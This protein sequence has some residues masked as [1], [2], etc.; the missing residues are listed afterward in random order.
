V[1][2]EFSFLA[3]VGTPPLVASEGRQASR[4]HKPPYHFLFLF[5]AL[6]VRQLPPPVKKKSQKLFC[7]PMAFPWILIHAGHEFDRVE[8]HGFGQHV[9]TQKLKLLAFLFAPA[10]L[11]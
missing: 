2:T 6:P 4:V 1:T 8:A 11:L 9:F 5:S 10:M 7:C 3:S